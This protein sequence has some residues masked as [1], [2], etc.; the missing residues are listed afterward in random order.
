MKLYELA[1]EYEVLIGM[2]ADACTDE[3]IQAAH[4]TL[5]GIEGELKIKIENCA[6]VL[7]QLEGQAAVA[8][9][10]SERLGKRASVI[11]NSVSR[12][13]DYMQRC[14]ESAEVRKI[15][16]ELFTV[17]IQKNPPHLEGPAVEEPEKLPDEYQ[18]VKT[19]VAA[20]KKKLLEDVKSG[21]VVD[22]VG[23]VQTESLRIR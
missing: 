14:M 22:G 10:E 23:L 17:A 16:G 20:D 4:D 2:L 21:K 8:K 3:E 7:K 12:L 13:K 15:E 9:A 6:K 11:T 1:N 19:T 5:E 18:V